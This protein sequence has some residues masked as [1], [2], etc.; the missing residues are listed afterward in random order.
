MNI[1]SRLFFEVVVAVITTNPPIGRIHY[2]SME[3]DQFDRAGLRGYPHRLR[4][5]LFRWKH[6][7]WMKGQID[8]QIPKLVKFGSFCGSCL[9]QPLKTTFL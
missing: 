6:F 3:E 9:V 1:Q 4:S 5:S 8:Q 7:I 2:C